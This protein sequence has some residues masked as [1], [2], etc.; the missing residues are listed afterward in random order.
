M[1]GSCT[2]LLRDWHDFY[3]LTG[4]AAATLVGLTFVAASLGAG[5]ASLGTAE[6]VRASLRAWVSPTL[7]HFGSVLVIAGIVNAPIPTCGWLAGLLTGSGLVGFAYAGVTSVLLWRH[8]RRRTRVPRE[9]WLFQVA[10]PVVGYLLI[11][12]TA[13]DLSAR[14]SGTLAGL[15]VAVGLL[16]ALGMRNAWGVMLWIAEQRAP[17]G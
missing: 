9:E 4:T 6:L 1:V 16:L 15:A 17:G 7:I 12:G 8:H 3:Q 14:G 11:V 10:L 2:E 13:V 5:I